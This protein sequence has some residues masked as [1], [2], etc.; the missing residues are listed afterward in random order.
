MKHVQ[1][2]GTTFSTWQN[3]A[4]ESLAWSLEDPVAPRDTTVGFVRAAYDPEAAASHPFWRHAPQHS[5]WL[6]RFPD[7]A[8]GHPAL[9]GGYIGLNT[10]PAFAHALGRI[11]SLVDRFPRLETVYV[12]DIQGPPMGCG[13]G[14]PACRSWDNA[15]GEKVA[16][17]TYENPAVRFPAEFFRALVSARPNLEW[18]PIVCPECE[19]GVEIDGVFDPDGPHGTDNCRGV[20]CVRPCALDFFPALLADLRAIAPRIGLLLT[21]DALEKD[22]PIF[23]PPRAWAVRANRHYGQDLLPVVEPPDAYAFQDALILTDVPQSVVPVAP[24]PG[25]IATVP[26]IRCGGCP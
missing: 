19:R 14:N 8:G 25:Y 20:A 5:E 6:R 13:C 16:P 2:S 10:R 22:H 18:V 11:M 4:A 26:A 17:T 23:G 12:M 7:F 1:V 21:V 3:T 9:V 24:P 15:P